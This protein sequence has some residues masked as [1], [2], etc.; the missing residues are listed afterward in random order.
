LT[1]EDKGAGPHRKRG[2]IQPSQSLCWDCRTSAEELT[3]G[4]K[5]TPRPKWG[6]RG[7][8]SVMANLAASKLEKQSSLAGP[9]IPDAKFIRDQ[10][11]IQ[12]VA[13]ELGL[14]VKG[15]QCHCWRIEAHPQWRFESVDLRP[16][17][18]GRH[19]LAGSQAWW[20]WGRGGMID[21]HQFADHQRLRTRVD[22]DGTKI[23]LG[24]VGHIY[25]YDDNRLGVIVIPNPP[26][27]RY[28]GFT[29]AA[30][31]TAGFVVVQDGD[32][33]GAATFDPGNSEQVIAAIRAAGVKRRRKISPE[34]RERAISVLA[35]SRRRADSGAGTAQS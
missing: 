33:E 18:Q 31:L 26:R 7:S 5:K 14:V 20:G 22:E 32:G 17:R 15:R 2:G 30:L 9:G 12:N 35:S 1:A 23:I 10:T 24:K 13:R 25:E 28:W 16:P 3:P 29:K 21:I 4:K 19:V 34:Q 27:M 8:S 11:P 6:P